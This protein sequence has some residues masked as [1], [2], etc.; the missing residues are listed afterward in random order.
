AGQSH[1]YPCAEMHFFTLSSRLLNNRGFSLAIPK[2]RI[3]TYTKKNF[4]I[5]PWLLQNHSYILEI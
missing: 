2:T 5:C 3:W 1:F 4:Y